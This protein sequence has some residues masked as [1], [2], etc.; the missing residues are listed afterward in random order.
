MRLSG[1]KTGSANQYN[2]LGDQ[3]YD[4]GGAR[5]TLD[6]N[7]AN[8][9]SLVD[10]VTGKTLVQHTRQSN[11]TYVDGDGVIRNAVTNLLL[12]SEDFSTT[13]TN[14]ESS[15]NI[16][17]A[18]APNGTTTA[19]ALVDTVNNSPH[20]VSQSVAG[21]AGSTSYTFSCYMKKGSKDFGSLI[22]G[23]NAS[24]GTGG[25]ASVF[26]DL[27]NGTIS[28]STSATGTIQAL[29][30]GWYRCTAT[31]TT[32][33]SPGTV[34][35][36][37]GSSLT[38]SAQTYE[39][40]GDEAIYL[41]GTQLE[42]SPTVG[43]YI[44]TTSTINSAP[45]FDHDPTTG[46]S[47][48]L[49]VEES[50]TNLIT[51]SSLTTGYNIEGA[52]ITSSTETNPEN[53]SFCQKILSNPGLA[54]Q[55][56]RLYVNSS[57]A[58]TITVSVFVKKDTHR[59]VYIG[60]GGISNSFT[61]LFDIEPG[62]TANRLLGQG[63]LGTH[64]NVNAGYQD[65]PNGWVRIWASG[66]TSGFNGF[67]VGFSPDATT[68]NITD[69]SANGTEAFFVY[70][71][72]YEDNVSFPTSYIP[73]TGTA[74]TRA[75]DVASISGSNFSSWF[76]P[77]AGVMYSD[78][79]AASNGSRAFHMEDTSRTNTERF[80]HRVIS[81]YASA[82]VASNGVFTSV[83]VISAGTIS[84][85]P[86][87]IKSCVGYDSSSAVVAFRGAVNSTATANGSPEPGE[88]LIGSYRGSATFANGPIARLT[89]WP[90]R[91]PNDTLQTITV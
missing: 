43:E 61:A 84:A 46:E 76:S 21:G 66:T 26:F 59:Y 8:N 85:F 88:M 64:T 81:N 30:N 25:G 39:G 51:D 29:P 22:F 15:E 40:D 31:A 14:S 57:S 82:E 35:G 50:R 54:V 77:T 24:W 70:G 5:P 80:G 71:A 12:Q 6:L 45:R 13:W 9:G 10:S 33:A 36:R 44:P 58:N 86:T 28:A 63:G 74:A 2:G 3:L 67:T 62:V 27:T 72:Q 17:V 1:T 79:T 90:Q 78:W 87:R 37:I 65:F 23:P 7:F 89:Y 16:N 69:W 38:G 91:L 83:S 32:V 18:V 42:Q 49:L 48:G 19:D 53:I 11:A 73:T 20:Y 68:Y 41:W 75:A 34:F 47:L 56:H 60:F 52:T 4:L 55:G